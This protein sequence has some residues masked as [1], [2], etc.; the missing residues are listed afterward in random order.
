MKTRMKKLPRDSDGQILREFTANGNEYIIL[1]GEDGLGALR[2]SALNR[3]NIQFG[4]A[5]TFPMIHKDVADILNIVNGEGSLAEIRTKLGQHIL[6]MLDGLGTIS[7]ER[8]DLAFWVC[9]LFIVRDG[10][11]LTKWIESEQLE[12][13]EDWNAEG[14]TEWDFFTLAGSSDKSFFPIYRATKKAAQEGNLYALV[15]NTDLYE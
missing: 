13:I 5:R 3:F 7:K 10:E 14:I 15:T 11:D 12:K 6:P 9:T 8:Y 1:N 4:M 2:T